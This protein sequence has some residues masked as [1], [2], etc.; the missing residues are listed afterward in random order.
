MTFK[1]WI[2]DVIS[3]GTLCGNY[4]AMTQ[5]AGSKL[6][7]MRIVLD[8]NGINW[9]QE[10]DAK[11]QPL[12]YETITSEFGNYING[13][14]MA[15]FRNEKGRGYTSSLYCC[16]MDD[17]HVKTTLVSILGCACDVWLEENS[18]VKLFVD[19]NCDLVIHCP[20]T[21]RCIVEYWDGAKVIVAKNCDCVEFIE[22]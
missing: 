8:A 6:A 18:F 13:K 3:N 15:E 1:D 12:P 5:G 20:C 4:T 14:Y 2:S 16:S 21:A 17:I 22:Q 19:K 10:M 7:L 11:G 9:L